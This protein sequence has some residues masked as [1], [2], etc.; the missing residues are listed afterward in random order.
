[1]TD[2]EFEEKVYNTGKDIFKR[3]KESKS[4]ILEKSYWNSKLIDLSTKDEYLKLQLFRFIDVLPSL[5]TKEQTARYMSEYFSE[6]KSILSSTVSALTKIASSNILGQITAQLAIDTSINEMAKTFIAGENISEI[7]ENILKMHKNNIAF[8]VDILGEAVL[9]ENEA[10][11]YT[12]EYLNLLT[13][14]QSYEKEITFNERL[15]KNSLGETP[16]INISVKLSSL[17]SQI[18]TVAFDHSV[19]V[20]K[21]RLKVI[22]DQAIEQN[23]FVYL[24]MEDYKLKN[25]TLTVFKELLLEAKYK[26]WK[27]AGIVIQAYL[28][29]SKQ[30]L[31]QLIEFTKKRGVPI[32]I[33]LVKG[34]YWDYESIIANQ[35]NWN[36]P[37]YKTKEET[38]TNYEDLTKILLDSYPILLPAIASHNIRS[39]AYA[40]TYASKINIPKNALEFQLLYGMADQI[41]HALVALG[42]RVRVYTPCGKLIPG[43]AYLV[44]RLLENTANQSFLKQTF[45]DDISEDEL[46]KSPQLK[47]KQITTKVKQDFINIPDTDFNEETNRLKYK[48][49]INTI[50]QSLPFRCDLIINNKKIISKEEGTSINP[51]NFNETISIYSKANIDHINEAISSSKSA[52]TKWSKYPVAK[53]TDILFKAAKLIEEKRFELSALISLEVGKSWI[54]A[55]A[56]ISESIDFLNYY[57]QQALKLFKY[58]KISSRMGEDNLSIYKSKGISAIIPPWNFPLAILCGMTSA[59]LACGNTVILKPAS[60]SPTIAYKFVK[61]LIEAGLP[62]GVC[63]Y[64]PGDGSIIGDYLIS[65][66]EISLIAFTGSREVGLRIN[67]LANKFTNEQNFIKKVICEMGGKNAIIIDES[68]D[69]DEAIK[70]SL[71]STFGYSGQKCSA[72]SRI[73]VLEEVYEQFITRYLE[74]VKSI[75]VGNIEDPQFYYGPVIDQRSLDNALKYIEI[76]KQEG[77]LLFGGKQISKTGFYLEPTVF[78]NINPKARIA[79]EEIF[80][81]IV[82]IIKTKDIL[83]AIDIANNV[84]YALTGSLFSRSPK[85]I[86]LAKEHFLTGNLYINRGCTG[87]KVCRQPFGGFKLSGIGSKAGG[88]DYLLQFVEPRVITENTLRRGFAPD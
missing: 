29:D 31:N 67:E 35:N 21:E 68:A 45:L 53:R 52:Y 71:Y 69:L 23:A 85:N 74:A 12:N 41:K 49:G 57:G 17:Y 83:S 36:S 51:S 48:E 80:A 33:R 2:K 44:R 8:T 65:H 25:I 46:L 47:R 30:D 58:E 37:V 32:S 54:E 79:Q 16:K 77:V 5:K 72:A 64:I 22:Y 81:P 34:A 1:M 18:S 14:L 78:T 28:K 84:S 63:N 39:I 7:K 55:D 50:R 24:D 62:E 3:I 76:G 43:M 9:S 66:P 13:G 4:N 70:A 75:S 19:K 73:I 15:H 61:I 38:D 42:Q 6:N 26:D 87:A 82:A 56:D 10:Q 60:Q 86:Q 27:H 88:K 11:Y 40:I 20:L 59:S